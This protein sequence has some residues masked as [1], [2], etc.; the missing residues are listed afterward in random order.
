MRFTAPACQDNLWHLGFRLV[1][2]R[3]LER[4]KKRHRR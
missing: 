1:L 3:P 2:V 4:K